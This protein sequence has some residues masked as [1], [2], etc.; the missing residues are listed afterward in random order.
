MQ[1]LVHK[2][3]ATV[4]ATGVFILL[5]GANAV[6]AESVAMP[7]VDPAPRPPYKEVTDLFHQELIVQ[8]PLNDDPASTISFESESYDAYL[9]EINDRLEKLEQSYDG[10]TKDNRLRGKW[11]DRFE[12]RTY[13]GDF[14]LVIGGRVE[15]DYTAFEPDDPIEAMFGPID[16]GGQFRRARLVTSAQLYENINFFSQYDFSTGR[17]RFASV[18][19]GLKDMPVF[20]NVR[21]GQF[22]EP[23]GLE[24]LTSHR[25]TT[26]MERALTNAI[27]PVRS[28]GIMLHDTTDDRMGTWWIGYFRESNST[29]FSQG[30]GGDAVTGRLT[31]LLWYDEQC[32][33]LLHIGGAVS[34]RTFLENSARFRNRP[35]SDLA[36]RLVDTGDIPVDSTTLIAAEIAA[37]CGPLLLQS[38]YIHN[39]TDALSGES[40]EFSAYYFNVSYFLT[41]EQRDYSRSNATFRRV[42]PNNNFA[43]SDCYFKGCGAWELAA[44]YSYVDLDDGTILGGRE[45]NTTFGLNWYWNPNMRT[46]FNYVYADRNEIGH[47]HIFQSRLQIDF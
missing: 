15:N 17:A 3:N 36:P 34:H 38:E 5:L 47:L 4:V 42:I 25:F 12:F 33:Q 31:R 7:P 27:T 13:D 35:E 30:D 18:F 24:R 37:T 46:M 6:L 32:N 29:G 41:G 45:S 26:F 19:L 39:F 10:L 20:H 22:E 21:I 44:R 16:G 1:A 40:L 8:D 11:N 2:A 28:T 9:S 14:R 23:L 43:W